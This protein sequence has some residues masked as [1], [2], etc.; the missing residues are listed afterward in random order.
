MNAALETI[1][2]DAVYFDAVYDFEFDGLPR[3]HGY[4]PKMSPRRGA[5]APGD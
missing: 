5:G 3:D 2:F 4:W 1:Y